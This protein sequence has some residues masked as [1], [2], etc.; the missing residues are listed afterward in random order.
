MPTTDIF[1]QNR[2]LK[3]PQIR[4]WSY[5]EG[6]GKEWGMGTS[7]G[8]KAKLSLLADMAKKARQSGAIQREEDYVNLAGGTMGKKGVP[9]KFK[10]GPVHW[11]VA[12]QG[13][14]YAPDEFLE[15]HP[16]FYCDYTWEG[17]GKKPKCTAGKKVNLE[18]Y[19]NLTDMF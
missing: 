11:N 8:S 14:E 10:K 1:Q 5:H 4:R 3:K 16:Q 2:K 6:R 12:Y 17:K 13:K 19:R 9:E 15:K 18:V 7:P